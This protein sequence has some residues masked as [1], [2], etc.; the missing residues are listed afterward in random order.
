MST[1]QTTLFPPPTRAKALD[2][3]GFLGIPFRQW[4]FTLQMLLPLRVI[5]TTAGSYAEDL[6]PA[7]L[8]STTG[9]S[10]QNQ[11]I[12][13]VKASSDGNVFTLNGGLDG[14][15]TLTAQWDVLRYK[16]DG[17]SW[18]PSCCGSGGGGGGPVLEV[19]GVA[20]S[21]QALL[22]LTDTDGIDNAL[23]V[24][25]EDQGSGDVQ[26][27]CSPLYRSVENLV[28][29]QITFGPMNPGF[30]DA[31]TYQVHVMYD[32]TSPLVN[33]GILSVEYIDGQNFVIK[34]SD[35]SDASRVRWFV[36]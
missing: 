1:T 31:A 13:Y 32:S 23:I 7:G 17:T 27:F 8:N 24:F 2:D 15:K 12:I 33:P 11:E 28:A 26:A 5:D 18:Y 34:S 36:I 22:N 30:S 21:D 16:S 3:K 29:G 4:L 35:P 10:N 9:Q 6:P 25:F 20:N 19:N 14:P